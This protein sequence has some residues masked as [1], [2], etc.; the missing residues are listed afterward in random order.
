MILNWIELMQY[1]PLG[2]GMIVFIFLMGHQMHMMD[3]LIAII[4]TNA[5]ASANAAMAVERLADVVQ[6]CPHRDHDREDL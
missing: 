1:G 5:E 2:V 4:T 3:R 6:G